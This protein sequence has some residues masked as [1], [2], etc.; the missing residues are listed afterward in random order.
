[1]NEKPRVQYRTR[2]IIEVSRLEWSE[3]FDH[4]DDAGPI[5]LTG[6][7]Y[8]IEFRDD[9]GLGEVEVEVRTINP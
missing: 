4:A 7:T 5:L 9:L 6:H 3:W 8:E 2:E 1:M